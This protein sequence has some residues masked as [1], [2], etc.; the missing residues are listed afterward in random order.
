[1]G[2]DEGETIET[3]QGEMDFPSI[4]F[5]Q[6]NRINCAFA[7]GDLDS[8]IT[9]LDI[10]EC[11]MAG[12]VDEEYEKKIKEELKKVDR[13]NKIYGEAKVKYRALMMLMHRSNL[14]PVPFV[15]S[16]V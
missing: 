12:Y 16:R 11:Q 10:L 15:S 7:S 9:S 14:L 3:M 2:K 13:K 8:A 5:L 1:M 4:L 6:L